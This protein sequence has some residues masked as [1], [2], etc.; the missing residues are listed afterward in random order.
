MSQD[1]E[2]KNR[3]LKRYNGIGGNVV[4]PDEVI[5]I[6][7]NAFKYCKRLTNI[8]IPDSVTEIGRS[9]F[10]YCT[11]LTNV[12]IPDSVTEIGDS[13]FYDCTSLTSI[14]IPES[15]TKIGNYAFCECNSL[16]TV[17]F[18]KTIPEYE[19]KA[20]H[21]SF[22]KQTKF[23]FPAHT[24]QTTKLPAHVITKMS[25]KGLATDDLTYILLNKTQKSYLDLLLRTDANPA[26]LMQHLYEQQGEKA[27]NEKQATTIANYVCSSLQKFSSEE[28]AAVLAFFE[29]THPATAKK[30]KENTDIKQKLEGKA[31]NPIEE[32]VIKA[33][34]DSPLDKDV[35]PVIKSGISYADGSGTSSVSAVAFVISEYAKLFYK[36][37]NTINGSMSSVDILCD[38]DKIP[39]SQ[40]ADHVAQALDKVALLNLLCGKLHGTQYRL[41]IM[42]Y[43]R[44][45]EGEHI[46]NFIS[47]INSRKKG[48]AKDRYWA[49]NAEESLYLNDS[50]EAAKY[51]EKI[52]KLKQYVAR[53]GMSIDEYQVKYMLPTFGMD[54]RGIISYDVGGDTVEVSLTPE[55][56]FS[57]YDVNS[58]KITKSFPKKSG[59]PDKNAACAKEFS[60]VKKDITELIKKYTV[61]LKKLHV[62][63]TKMS[64]ETWEAI[65]LRHPVIQKLAQLLIWRDDD[66]CFIIEENWEIF[67]V[68][69]NPYQP[70]KTIMLSH[71]LDMDSDEVTAWQKY[72]IGRK[73]KQ[74]FTQIWEPVV[75]NDAI[76]KTIQNR[77]VGAVL[78]NSERTAFRKKMKDKGID[79]HAGDIFAEY[80][81]R[82]GCYEFN[83]ENDMFIGEHVTLN[84]QIDEEKKEITLGKLKLSSGAA[85]KKELNAIIAELDII[86]L[87]NGVKNDRY[88]LLNNT[89]L[90][91]FTVMQINELIELSVENGAINCSAILLDYKNKNFASF[92][93]MDKFTLE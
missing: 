68:D 19:S 84:Y 50:V 81:H 52:G 48:H 62:Y 21:A 33:I 70:L 34:S 4:I 74:L 6:G 89:L 77:Y 44:Y 86:T 57:F 53:R 51:F 22:P 42:A 72:L 26:D 47:E 55:L 30:L 92:D 66:R 45:A 31:A 69:G 78:T 71:V 91:T 93:P 14:T 23:C 25:G 1:F 43:A 88:E 13:V 83:T 76:L 16:K 29:K 65:Y 38:G 24:V 39:S 40:A 15:V 9:A 3:I 36:N 32:Y 61:V 7:N 60:K 80:N 17:F 18:G 85:N 35:A 2:I 79:V 28:L 75:I 46:Q 56:K 73:Q 41:Y 49:Q 8:V 63:G 54:E 87:R 59:D 11:S 90:E 10:S 5:K 20:D 58:G 64:L 67:D 82:A 37:K 27:L 12:V